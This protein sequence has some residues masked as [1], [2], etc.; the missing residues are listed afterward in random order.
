MKKSR[1]PPHGKSPVSVPSA[2][3]RGI[4][5]RCRFSRPIRIGCT[6]AES[7]KTCCTKT[8][9]LF[10]AAGIRYGKALRQTRFR[11]LKLCWNPIVSPNENRQPLLPVFCISAQ[12]LAFLPSLYFFGFPLS[13]LQHH[14][15]CY[16]C[17]ELAVRRLFVLGIHFH[18]VPGVDTFDSS[19]VPCHFDGMP[20]RSLYLACRCFKPLR[21]RR[22]QWLRDTVDHRRM[23]Y[24]QFD[25]FPQKLIPL[26][27]RRNP[28]RYEYVR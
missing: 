23:F 7:G 18:S 14:F 21:Y 25:S 24:R 20:Y 13:R 3:R 8:A 22:I 12:F 15:I 1:L 6:S 16:Q 17:Y 10:G 27:I 9:F 5:I 2:F 26:E 28:Y 19:S 4:Y 11:L